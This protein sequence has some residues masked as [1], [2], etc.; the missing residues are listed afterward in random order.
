MKWIYQSTN[1]SS[2]KRYCKAHLVDA[3]LQ[4]KSNLNNDSIDTRKVRLIVIKIDLS[5]QN[6]SILF[7]NRSLKSKSK[8]TNHHYFC[9]SLGS[10]SR[11]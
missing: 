5:P 3:I 1:P 8:P 11:F 4:S 10:K 6:N 7:K 2:I 9:I